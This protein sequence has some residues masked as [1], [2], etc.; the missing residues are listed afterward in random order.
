MQVGC[1]EEGAPGEGA[2]AATINHVKVDA[3]MRGFY[4]WRRVW[5][6]KARQGRCGAV[7]RVEEGER[8]M[9]WATWRR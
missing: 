5:G 1:E 6:D 8:E 7:E 9:V 2:E 4:E 3:W